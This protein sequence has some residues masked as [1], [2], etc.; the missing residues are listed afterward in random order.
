[1]VWFFND[2]AFF[3][4]IVDCMIL[5]YMPRERSGKGQ[6]GERG[7]IRALCESSWREFFV[8][9]GHLKHRQYLQTLSSHAFTVCG[10]GGGI[11]LNPKLFE[12][13]LVGTIPIIREN[14]PYTDIYERYDFPVVIIKEWRPNT[15]NKH[16]L[17]RWYDKYKRYFQD[18]TKR[19]CMLDS[20]SLDFWI[21]EVSHCD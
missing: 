16:N 13:L 12:A 17:R 3:S 4:T 11:D 21:N 9:T 14:K 7:D 10:H 2:R 18:E 19:G 8:P 15:I 1:M 5:V 20:M 6:Y